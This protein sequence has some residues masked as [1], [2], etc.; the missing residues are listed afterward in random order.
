MN[1]D[2]GRLPPVRHETSL[3]DAFARRRSE[4]DLDGTALS[5][6]EL[7]GVLAGARHEETGWAYPSAHDLRPVEVRALVR[8]DEHA[9]RRCHA[10]DPRDNTLRRRPHDV[11]VLLSEAAHDMQP[12]LD[13][14]PVVLAL[15]AEL[16]PLAEEFETQDPS[17]LRGRDFVMLEAGA[18]A[19]CVLLGAAASGIG[20]VLVAGI[21]QEACRALL[22]TSR[23]VCSLIALGRART[24]SSA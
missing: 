18:L 13:S 19:Q 2:Q 22:G 7:A 17:G 10:F 9:V 6:T 4:R 5:P 3:S 15:V 8:D 20:A 12:W 23:H 14:A 11:P 16:G 21:R 1:E 24:T